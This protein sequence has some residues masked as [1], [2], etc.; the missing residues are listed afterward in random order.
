[1]I[2]DQSQQFERIISESNDILILISQNPSGDA[3]GAAWALNFFL[4]KQNKNSTVVFSGEDSMKKFSF[5]PKPEKVLHELSGTQDFVLSFTT[6]HNKIIDVKTERLEDE[7]RVYITPEKGS[8][9]PRDFSFI[10]SRFKYDALIVLGSPDRESLGKVFEES[11]DIFYEVP[12]INIDFNSSNDR[13]GQLNIIDISASST[14]EILTDFFE[15]VSEDTID[16]EMAEC[17]LTGIID[18]TNSFQ[19]KN[20]TPKAL[21][22]SAMLMSK[23]ADQQKIIRYLF[24]TQ[25]LALL[26]LWGRVMARLRWEQ[27]S[28]LIWAPILLED[29]VQSRSNPK[30]ISLILDKIME[31]Y[32][33]GKIFMIAFNETPQTC[34]ISIKSQNQELLKKIAIIFEGVITNELCVFNYPGGEVQ[35][36]GENIAKKLKGVVI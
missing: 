32:S 26:K 12:V 15:K 21:Q 13:F 28:E 2:S 4:K 20:T 6:K 31:N 36:A 33:N 25:P 5:L 27:E 10:P 9:D 29:F 14:S 24:K 8:I 3:I 19:N 7:L 18:S 16:S 11:P 30:D 35:I 34:K 17:L 1:M 23:G 22:M